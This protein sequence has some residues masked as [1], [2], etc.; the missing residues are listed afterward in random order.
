MSI[1]FVVPVMI[2]DM[3]EGKELGIR[4]SKLFGAFGLAIL[5]KPR[6]SKSAEVAQSRFFLLDYGDQPP[7][8]SRHLVRTQSVLQSRHGRGHAE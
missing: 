7:A 1:S 2:S 5:E 6:P 3:W 8:S 4:V